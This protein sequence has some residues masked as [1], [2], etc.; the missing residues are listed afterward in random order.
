MGDARHGGR[1]RSPH[2]LDVP[3]VFDNVDKAP[4][5]IGTGS[6]EA[7]RVADAMS[8]SW[9][10]FARTGDPNAPGLAYWPPFD[11]KN[12]RTMEFNVVSRA[13]TDPIY[14]VLLLDPIATTVKAEDNP[15]RSHGF[16]SAHAPT[17]K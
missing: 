3:L 6:V 14:D 5:T 8:A 15:F 16:P 7:Q 4:S 1:L 10:A 11:E 2:G 12:Q 17:C 9:L 13:V